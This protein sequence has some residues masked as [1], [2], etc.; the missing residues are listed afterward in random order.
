MRLFSTLVTTG[1]CS[2][3]GG[4][5]LC[6]MASIINITNPPEIWSSCSVD[7]IN[8]ALTRTHN[9]LARCL[10]NVPQDFGGNAVCGD[11]VI[12]GDEECDC[13]SPQVSFLLENDVEL[14]FT[15]ELTLLD[16]VKVTRYVH[17][18]HCLYY[19]IYYIYMP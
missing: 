14:Q 18:L 13:G 6:V 17:I 5:S 15:V 7:S 1:S 10:H 4:S 12:Q 3:S 16:R 2:C 9:N 8:T 19:I 11:C